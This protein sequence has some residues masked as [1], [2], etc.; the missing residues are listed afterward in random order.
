M[1]S[2][3][4][5]G[6][7]ADAARGRLG[8]GAPSSA[9]AGVL[10]FATWAH[11]APRYRSGPGRLATRPSSLRDPRAALRRELC[12]ARALIH[13]L[14]DAR[15][16][17]RGL[18]TLQLHVSVPPPKRA[19]EHSARRWERRHR[20]TRARP[21]HGRASVVESACNRAHYWNGARARRSCI[22]HAPRCATSTGEMCSRSV[23]SRRALLHAP[24]PR[25]FPLPPCQ[26]SS[27]ATQSRRLL[28]GS[29]GF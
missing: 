17:A 15:G 4:G 12:R 6:R 28:S 14:H 3:G 18:R 21:A 22:A 24:V 2:H 19:C 13:F 7:G 26:R 29:I 5:D 20:V 23:R 8:G 11:L 16:L 27:L 25:T 1:A 9:L 10:S